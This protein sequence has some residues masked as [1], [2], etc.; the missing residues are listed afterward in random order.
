MK[1]KLGEF[2]KMVSCSRICIRIKIPVY[3][4][5]GSMY[6]QGFVRCQQGCECYLDPKD[7]VRSKSFN[8]LLCP[9]CGAQVRIKA[10]NRK[11][12]PFDSY[13]ITIKERMK[14]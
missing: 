6:D 4:K 9:C 8:K 10:R 2:Q 5:D 13:M 3:L 14:L 1:I 7:C 12:D 11:A